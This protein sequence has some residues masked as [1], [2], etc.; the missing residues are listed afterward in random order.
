MYYLVSIS[1]SVKANFSPFA[2][3][4]TQYHCFH[5]IIPSIIMEKI[6][7]LFVFNSPPVWRR[8]SS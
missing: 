8:V 5:E 4:K 2:L 6:A 7:F 1:V 3:G